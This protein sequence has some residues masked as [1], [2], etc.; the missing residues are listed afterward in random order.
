MSGSSGDDA[1]ELRW[2]GKYAPDGSRAALPTTGVALRVRERHGEPRPRPADT[3]VLGDNLLVLEA[4]VREHAGSVDLVYIDPPF[5]TGNAFALARKLPDASTL[6]VPAFDDAWTGGLGEFLAML[7]PRLRLIHAL[8]GPRGS[9]YVHVDPTVGHAVKLLLDDIFGRACFQREIVWRI[10]WV[11]GFKTR[12]RNWIRNHDTI[13]FYTKHPSEF[14]FH[15]RW[16]P[17]PS[18]Y[19][20]RDGA[21]GKS[22]GIAIDDVWNAGEAELELSGRASL[23]SIQIK[24]FSKEKTGWA[25]QK[26]ESLLERIIAASSNPGEL[27]VDVF[28]GSG[29]TAAVAHA[30]G[31][32]FLVADLSEAAIQITRDRLL[33]LGV[34]DLR[35]CELDAVER[36]VMVARAGDS[37]VPWLLAQVEA[38]AW[39]GPAPFVGRRGEVAVAF[40]PH[41]RAVDP[42]LLDRLRATARELGLAGVELLAFAWTDALALAEPGDALVAEHEDEPALV[43]MQIGRGIASAS[44]RAGTWA[45]GSVAVWERPRLRVAL[46][47]DSVALCELAWRRPACVPDSLRSHAGL[48]ALLGWSLLDAAGQVCFA[49][50]RREGVLACVAE[51]VELV[52]G[53]RI[54]LDD[55]RG[56]RHVFGLPLA[57]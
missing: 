13:F 54:A 12:A 51:R 24:S 38:E 49:A 31:R 1:V 14:T 53:M 46:A 15:K 9:L 35:V 25:T 23:D 21:P 22:P 32:R 44:A 50:R 26:N 48:D 7:D 52:P 47:P 57:K 10:G 45:S 17:H 36:D 27:V 40:V 5:A 8:L 33:E 3:L 30:L 16:V 2:P 4:L 11:S 43:P 34:A 42:E 28:A 19:Q 41:D 39:A 56:L 18:G 55:Q 29:T 6:R 20:R 37:L